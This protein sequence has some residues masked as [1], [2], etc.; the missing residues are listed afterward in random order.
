MD[1]FNKYDNILG[2]SK[3]RQILIPIVPKH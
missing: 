1:L 3:M 2:D